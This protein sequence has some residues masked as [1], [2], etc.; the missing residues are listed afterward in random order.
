MRVAAWIVAALAVGLA[1]GCTK[2]AESKTKPAPAAAHPEE[3]PHGGAL[4][5]WGD[6]EAYH[7]EFTVD[8]KTKQATVYILGGDA[9]TAKPI[10]TKE[11]TLTLKQTPPVAVKLTASPQSGDPEGKSSRF[12]GTHDAFGVEKEFEG[13]IVATVDGAQ[14]AGDF[15]EKDE[16]G[17]KH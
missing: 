3:G 8:H 1:A 2:P 12:V 17:H 5:E 15:K 13:S 6:D 4:A 14:R 10:A 16:H 7:A 9:K 11:L